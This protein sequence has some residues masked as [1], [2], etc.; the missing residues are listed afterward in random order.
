M[1]KSVIVLF[2]RLFRMEHD[3]QGIQPM[4]KIG[5][6]WLSAYHTTLAIHIAATTQ[7]A[8]RGLAR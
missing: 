1:I 7:S 2:S 6:G 8:G 5:R 4:P 3:S